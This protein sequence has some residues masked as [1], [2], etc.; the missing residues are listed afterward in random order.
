L[1]TFNVVIDKGCLDTFLFRSKHG[2]RHKLLHQVLQT[3]REKV[4]SGGV[5]LVISPRTGLS[6]LLRSNGIEFDRQELLL[7]KGELEGDNADQRRVFLYV[8]RFDSSGTEESDGSV[9][10]L[11][12]SAVSYQEDRCPTCGLLAQEFLK[13]RKGRSE[14]YLQRVWLGHCTHCKA[15]S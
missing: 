15:S 8:C 9:N 6:K 14:D 7:E 10:P 12:S 13:A 5:Y 4:A 2:E 11:N 3:I 1:Q